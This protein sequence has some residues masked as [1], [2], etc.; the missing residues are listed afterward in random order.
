[1]RNSMPVAHLESEEEY[2]HRLDQE[3]IE[4]L[5]KRAAAEEEHRSSGRHR[6]SRIPGFWRGWRNLGTRTRR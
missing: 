6:T 1:M 4:E 3:L 5:R 2:F